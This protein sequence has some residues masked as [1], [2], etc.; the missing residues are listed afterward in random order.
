MIL[1]DN[2]YDDPN[3]CGSGMQMFN[4]ALMQ[5]NDCIKLFYD[6]KIKTTGI[7]ERIYELE[8]IMSGV[9]TVYDLRDDVSVLRTS[10]EMI[11]PNVNSLEGRIED[12]EIRMARIETK[13]GHLIGLITKQ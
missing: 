11:Q 1:R 3:G 12:M 4:E 10:V 8:N 5:L 7:E 13:L 6:V 9:D 2:L